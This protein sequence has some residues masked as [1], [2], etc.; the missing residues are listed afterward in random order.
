MDHLPAGSLYRNFIIKRTL[1]FPLI[2]G[3][4]LMPL[5]L[6]LFSF[7]GERERERDA[8]AR[9]IS[10][11]AAR[12]PQ[13][14]NHQAALMR[15]FLLLLARQRELSAPFLEG[16]RES[17]LQAAAPLFQSLG[18]ETRITHLYFHT[19]DGVN[20]L[21]VHQPGRFGDRIERL[22]LKRAMETGQTTHGIE[23][24]PLGSL[25][26]RVVMPWYQGDL[27]IGYL[28]LGLEVSHLVDRLRDSL[29]LPLATLLLKSNLDRTLW[30]EGATALGLDSEWDR[31]DEVVCVDRGEVKEPRGLEAFIRSGAWKEPDPIRTVWEGS[32]GNLLNFHYFAIPIR[33]MD[34]QTAGYLIGENEH[35]AFDDSLRFSLSLFTVA[36]ALSTVI[37]ILLFRILRETEKRVGIETQSRLALDRLLQ[38]ALVNQPFPQQ[39]DRCLELILMG[40]KAIT[41]HKGAIFLVDEEGKKLNLVSQRGLSAKQLDKCQRVPFGVCLCGRAASEKSLVFSTDG[42]GHHPSHA[43]VAAHH[44]HYALPILLQETLL[45][46]LTVQVEAGHCEDPDE[47][48][49]LLAAANT[50]ASLIDRHETHQRL[51]HAREEAEQAARAKSEFLATM[52][53]EIRTPMNVVLGLSAL[54]LETDSPPEQRQHLELIHRSGETLLAIINDVLDFSRIDSGKLALVSLPF[55]PARIVEETSLFLGLTAR[56]KGLRLVAEVAPGVPGSILGDGGRV[57]QVLVNLVGNAIKFTDRG[58]VRVGLTPHPEEA[59]HLLFT[60]A[61]SGIGIAP[62]DRE[63]IFDRFTQADSGISRRHGGTGL[64]L[65]ISRELVGLMGGRLWVESRPGE[66]STFFFTL[67]APRGEPPEPRPE[68]ATPAVEAT[69]AT[70]R[71]ILLAEDSEDNQLLFQA[72]LKKTPHRLVIAN[73]GSEAVACV[74]RESFDLVFMDIQMPNMDGYEATRAIRLWERREGRHPLRIV[75]LSA[76]ASITRREESLEA[77][78]D[79][80]LS[81]PIDKQRFLAAIHW[82]DQLAEPP[83]SP[84]R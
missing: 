29:G 69:T 79:D 39:M 80:H 31:F 84:D 70:P 6:A 38:A 73:D 9:P 43:G 14:L 36:V 67:P 53:H 71:K 7:S 42:R 62:H 41:R 27:P 76:H 81:K 15:G 37:A 47:K 63:R 19:R 17:L 1:L 64:G 30:Q 20:F 51:E 8:V 49:F 54:L 12:F 28:E 44:G 10:L 33:V 40:S 45:G 50:L 75:A 5:L 21:R 58:H 59:D 56:K 82:N 48:A 4:V 23:L 32:E 35:R 11:L 26:L 66:G 57:R 24:G 74:Q 68:A 16:D 18:K 78:C 34:G 25:T 83:G 46:V 22:T 3:I 77:G 72:Y 13:E 60:V 55:S 2:G 61:D 65:T 52:S